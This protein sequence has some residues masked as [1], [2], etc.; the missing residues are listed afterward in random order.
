MTEE[1]LEVLKQI[2]K[3]DIGSLTKTDI[4]FLRARKSYLS[5]EE[6]EKFAEVLSEV[7]KETKKKGKPKK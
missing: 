6:T 1:F 3:K 2:T 5:E 7:K 4:E